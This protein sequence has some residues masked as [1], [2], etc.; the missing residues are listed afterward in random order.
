MKDQ[1]EARVETKA[2]RIKRPSIFRYL[3]SRALNALP[4][5]ITP[6]RLRLLLGYLVV[7]VL[8]VYGWEQIASAWRYVITLLAP[9]TALLGALLALK[10]SVVVV[11][12]F[13]LLSALF[14]LFF[15]FLTVVLKPGIFKAIFIPQLLAFACLLYTSPSPRDG[16]LSRMPSSA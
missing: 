11:S 8:G 4:A 5:F 6:L 13:T 15:G 3:E 7:F 1:V 12:V 10:L 2:G 14:K 9:V 16:L